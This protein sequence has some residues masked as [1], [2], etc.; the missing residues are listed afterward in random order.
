MVDPSARPGRLSTALFWL[1]WFTVRM[2]LRLFFRLRIEGR[3]PREGPFVLAAN[4]ISF[5]DPIV[6]GSAAPRRVVFLMTEVVYRSR[7]MGWF[8]RWN[9]AIPLSTRVPNRE[10]MRR[11]RTMLQQGRVIGIFPEGGISRD[12]LPLLGSP[13][14]VSL[15]LNEGVPIIPV[16]ILGTHDAL[17]PGRRLPRLKRIT[18]RFGTPLTPAE[19]ENAGSDRRERLQAATRLIMARIAELTGQES[20]E[21]VLDAAA[22][23]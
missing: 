6:L 19:L 4:H 17:P 18:V 12:G 1:L 11:A 3:I 14:A 15:V 21:S 16:G 23:R 13:G 2:G 7:Q 10:S 20:R 9:Q 22:A 5:I 8:Y